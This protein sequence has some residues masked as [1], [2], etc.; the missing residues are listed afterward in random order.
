MLNYLLNQLTRS[1]GVFFRTIRAFFTRRATG[2]TTRVRRVTNFSRNATKAATAAVQSAVS[3]AQKP[4]R[5]EDYVETRRLLISKALLLKIVIAAVG[6]GLIIYFLIWPFILSHFLTARFY[7]EDSRV[8]NWT[9]RV[10]VYA[11]KEKT[12]PLYAGRLE[13]GV[14]QGRGSEYDE[15]GVLCYEGW[16]QDGV[17][18][19][20]GTAYEDGVMIYEGQFA[21]G[22]YEGTGTAYAD[23]M[24]VYEGQFAGGVRQ[25][26]GKLYEDGV[27]RYEGSF[28]DD[29]AEGEGTSYYPSGA[30]SY[31][32]QFAAGLPEGTGTE[33]RESGGK[34]YEGGF[35][36]GEYSGTGTLYL[37]EGGTLEA[38]FEAG[39]PLGVVEWHRGGRL[40]YQGEWSLDQP[41]GLG[42]LYTRTG[43]AVYTG[44]FA[45][46]TLDGGQLLGLSVD[47]LREMLGADNT[48]NIANDGDG[49]LV[50][51]RQLGLA[52]LCSFATQEQESQVYA[53]YLF[54]PEGDW[55]RLLPGMDRVALPA[56]PEGT[57]SWSG[58]QEFTPPPGVA[59]EAGTYSS[60]VYTTQDSRVTILT[61]SGADGGCVLLHWSSLEDLPDSGLEPGGTP[62]GGS[63]GGDG[64]MEALLAALDLMETPGTG[65]QA[66]QNPYYGTQDPGQALAGCETPEQAG[67]LIDAMLSYW[68]QAELQCTLEENLARTQAQ[69]AQARTEQS[70][71]MDNGDAVAALEEEEA[72]LLTAID[73][74]KAERM[75]AQVQAQEAAG[76][77]PADYALD[78]LLL[79]FEPSQQDVSQVALVAAAYA[80]STG[81]TVDSAALTAQVKNLL[82][83][84]QE[85]R[86]T[87]LSATDAYEA[88]G[89]QAREAAGAFAMGTGDRDSWYEALTAQADARAALCQALSAFT[90]QANA[91]NQLT[92]GWVS[93]TF[94]WY[95]DTLDPLFQSAARQEPEEEG[96]SGET[97]EPETSPAPTPTPAEPESSPEASAGAEPQASGEIDPESSPALG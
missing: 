9:G 18:A 65:S 4:T 74:C 60:Q 63:A 53:V 10:V 79:S 6:A 88:A 70:M 44:E 12:L 55:I 14:L 11:D 29:T 28:A 73:A 21:N 43:T 97:E 77:D 67:A 72:E 48:E 51:S 15:N 94:G 90:S 5:R 7:V 87:V 78:Q 86:D 34:L 68:Q 69:L 38:E 95:A 52:A 62:D 26:Q 59:V 96:G 42:T 19:G 85:A 76:A 66:T 54:A 80:Q 45:G 13:E 2:I 75:R 47:E 36:A 27:L 93:R 17:R 81:E 84:L 23:G 30:V 40:Y 64:R 56:W 32:G 49:F 83:D 3:V 46:G 37:D 39:E 24:L 20:S 71:G 92:G 50:V 57:E 8:D 35:A 31:K 41:S 22:T 82:L 16:F 25:G 1:A 91:L 89:V 61:A 33:Y 58:Q